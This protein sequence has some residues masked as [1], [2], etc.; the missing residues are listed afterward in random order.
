M[1]RDE[2]ADTHS[3]VSKMPLPVLVDTVLLKSYLLTDGQLVMPF[4]QS[5]NQCDIEECQNILRAYEKYPELVRLY[6][7]HGLHRQAL[8]LLSQL[9]QSSNTLSSLHGTAPTVQYLRDLAANPKSQENVDLVLEFSDWVLRRTPDDG[10]SIFTHAHTSGA[11]LAD[12]IPPAMVLEHLKKTAETEVCVAYLESLITTGESRPQFHNE[13]IFF[14]LDEVLALME[15]LPRVNKLMLAGT[16][17]GRLGI[18]RKKLVD[19]LRRSTHYSP[20]RLLSKFPRDRLLEERA[21]LLSRIS[22]HE[23]A[24]SIYAHQLKNPRMA[25]E[26][27]ERNYNDNNEEERGMYLHLMK[28]YLKPDAAALGGT[29]KPPVMLEPALEL[30]SRHADKLDA[31]AGLELI[32]GDTPLHKLMPFFETVLTKNRHDMRN[33]QVVKNLLRAEHLQARSECLDASRFRIYI[34]D[35]TVCTHCRKKLGNSAFA[36]YP[37]G[38]L[39]HYICYTQAQQG[40]KRQY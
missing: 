12:A 3:G 28:V 29:E 4:L 32:P 18:L 14:Y 27:C 34:D 40:K 16:E 8:E 20:E 31:A 6:Q 21:V 10:L 22:Q 33:S 15:K 19:L 24:L 9:G 38:E 2:A 36:R 7:S 30:M 26:Y 1:G 25:E 35:D 23:Q 39:V 17:A 37:N 13:L 11:N 5:D